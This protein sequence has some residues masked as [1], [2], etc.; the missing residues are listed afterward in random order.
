MSSIMCLVFG[1]YVKNRHNTYQ[2]DPVKLRQI[3]FKNCFLEL[4]FSFRVPPETAD[5][6][7]S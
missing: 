2:V 3:K 5:P 4:I 7:W 6:G 1:S